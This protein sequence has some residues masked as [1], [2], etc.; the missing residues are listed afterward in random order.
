MVTSVADWHPVVV[1][2][3]GFFPEHEF[4]VRRRPVYYVTFD[5]ACSVVFWALQY[6]AEFGSYL[7]QVY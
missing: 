3:G 5:V 6:A 4:I 2:V 7:T 1:R